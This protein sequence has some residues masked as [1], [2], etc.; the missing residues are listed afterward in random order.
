MFASVARFARIPAVP[1]LA[2]FRRMATAPAAGSAPFK[3][4]GIQQ[5]AVGGLS[6]GS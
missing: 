2:P 5:I 6:K 3:I 1:A 4:L